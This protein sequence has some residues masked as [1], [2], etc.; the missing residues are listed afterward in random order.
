MH[1]PACKEDVPTS[2]PFPSAPAIVEAPSDELFNCS[3]AGET[4]YLLQVPIGNA[5]AV[6]SQFHSLR[7]E[8]VMIDNLTG[9][10]I[11][12]H[13]EGMLRYPDLE[14]SHI[15]LS[16]RSTSGNDTANVL[17]MITLF[18]LNGKKHQVAVCLSFG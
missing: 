14:E 10:N 18:Q 6:M 15:T 2:C 8:V 16:V 12:G 13:H 5:T 17:M 11:R 9:D 7:Y 1:G 4:E 3:I